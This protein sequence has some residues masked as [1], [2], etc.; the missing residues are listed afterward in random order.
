MDGEIARWS[1]WKAGRLNSSEFISS[2]NDGAKSGDT[3]R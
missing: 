1:V 3:Y 2:C